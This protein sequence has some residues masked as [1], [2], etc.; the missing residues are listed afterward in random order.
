MTLEQPLGLIQVLLDRDAEYGDR[1]DAAMDLG[2]FNGITV[3][4]AL[5]Q[6]GCD[7]GAEDDL[8]DAC[9]ESL[10]EIWSRKRSVNRAI[11]IRL[12]PA[13]RRAALATLRSISPDLATDLDS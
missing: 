5:A 4:D 10:A 13:G 11:F 12:A 3:E 6:V 2:A 9:G 8:A 7:D 1:H